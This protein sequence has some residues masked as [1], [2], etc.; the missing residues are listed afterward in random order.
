MENERPQR[1]KKIIYGL[2]DYK[3]RGGEAYQMLTTPEGEYPVTDICVQREIPYRAQPIGFA[4]KLDLKPY[5]GKAQSRPLKI[6]LDGLHPL[7]Y[8]EPEQLLYILDSP[9]VPA[10]HDVF[11]APWAD[12]HVHLLTRTH[13]YMRYHR[14]DKRFL[15]QWFNKECGWSEK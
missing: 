10:G 11:A 6:E 2:N 15:R 14:C 8:S 13:D 12:S 7:M 4:K 3:R 9:Y 5:P 1:V